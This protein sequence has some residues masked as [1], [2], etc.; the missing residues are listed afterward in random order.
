MAKKSG[1]FNGLQATC[2][3]ISKISIKYPSQHLYVLVKSRDSNRLCSI[4]NPN[5]N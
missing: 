1:R 4:G 5:L 3:S 2:N